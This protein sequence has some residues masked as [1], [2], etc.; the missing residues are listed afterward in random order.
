M[1]IFR[2]AHKRE[3][4]CWLTQL[5]QIK[6]TVVTLSTP[7]T[8]NLS[9]SISALEMCAFANMNV[10]PATHKSKSH[11]VKEII[12][13]DFIYVS[14]SHAYLWFMRSLS[15]LLSS[16]LLFLF[17]NRCCHRILLNSVYV[18][19]ITCQICVEF[20]EYHFWLKCVFFARYRS[21]ICENKIS[22]KKKKRVESYRITCTECVPCE[23]RLFIHRIYINI[24]RNVIV[25]VRSSVVLCLVESMLTYAK[26][27]LKAR[28]WYKFSIK[29]NWVREK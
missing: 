17:F 22:K 25:I 11:N 21:F 29:A 20:D 2:E 26:T 6:T 12:W 23:M 13:I 4:I 3:L 5:N 18:K 16:K 24:I 27:K 1:Y 10:L 28:P 19:S 7:K 9:L 14:L 8:H 15:M